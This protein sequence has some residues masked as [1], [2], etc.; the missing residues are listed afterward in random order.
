MGETQRSDSVASHPIKLK[1]ILA[2]I[3]MFGSKRIKTSLVDIL[4]GRIQAILLQMVDQLVGN[5]THIPKLLKC[6]KF[7]LCQL[8]SGKHFFICIRTRIENLR[9]IELNIVVQLRLKRAWLDLKKWI[10]KNDNRFGRV[11]Y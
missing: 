2:S 11:L 5:I 10:K 4:Q 8:C 7:N 6:L 9:G 3:K 1:R